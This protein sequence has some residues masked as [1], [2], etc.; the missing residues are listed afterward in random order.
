MKKVILYFTLLLPILYGCGSNDRGELVGI[1]PKKKWFAEQPFGMVSIPG[2][3]F[4]MGRQDEDISGMI[5]SPARTVTVRQFYMDETEITN[6]EYKQFIF[7]VRDSIT[8]TKLAYMA[9]FISG[10]NPIDSTGTA[11]SEGIYEFAFKVKDTSNASAYE[12]YMFENY[13][14]I[15]T[16]LDSLKPLNWDL[17]IIWDTNDYPDVHYVY[18]YICFEV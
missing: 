7:W 12:K 17:D 16:G 5:N 2:G 8:R 13:Y 10:G 18:I 3:S 11:K 15:G 1:N 9:D 14:D 4:T 6:L